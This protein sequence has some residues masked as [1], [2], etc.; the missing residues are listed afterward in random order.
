MYLPMHVA[1][2]ICYGDIITKHRLQTLK[3]QQ[4][5]ERRLILNY[6]LGIRFVI[7]HL[8][9]TS[10]AYELPICSFPK[11][12]QRTYRR[13][14]Q[15]LLRYMIQE[16]THLLSELYDPIFVKVNSRDFSIQVRREVTPT[17]ESLRCCK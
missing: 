5:S 2:D 7:V 1:G 10:S 16:Y 12:S 11:L 14:N 4:R 15:L 17:A 8:R 6:Q 9:Q 3:C 13:R